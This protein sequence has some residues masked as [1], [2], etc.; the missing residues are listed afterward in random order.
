M[1]HAFVSP[2]TNFRVAD[3]YIALCHH[4]GWAPSWPGLQAFARG[5]RERVL[6]RMEEVGDHDA[7]SAAL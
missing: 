2:I 6:S 7:C 4:Y 5:D 3:A 1:Q